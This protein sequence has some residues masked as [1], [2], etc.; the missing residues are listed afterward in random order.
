MYNEQKTTCRIYGGTLFFLKR[1][2]YYSITIRH[3]HR[4]RCCRHHLNLSFLIRK[5]SKASQT[6]NAIL[7]ATLFIR[8]EV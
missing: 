8:I 1:Y 7:D 4:R 5:H 2:F 6:C 3:H